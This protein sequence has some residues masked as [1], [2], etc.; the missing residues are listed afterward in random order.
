[1]LSYIYRATENTA[2]LSPRGEN[3]KSPKTSDST[4]GLSTDGQTGM[5]PDRRL[6]IPQFVY[7]GLTTATAKIK[8]T[9]IE[10]RRRSRVGSL[11]S[12]AAHSCF[13]GHSVP[14]QMAGSS[15]IDI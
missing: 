14:A 4:Y 1:M 2:V 6:V 9:T 7:S 15:L 13:Q 8:V 3:L 11:H 10:P 12:P 5:Q